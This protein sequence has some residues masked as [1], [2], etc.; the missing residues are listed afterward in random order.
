VSEFFS[1][2]TLNYYYKVWYFSIYGRNLAKAD[3]YQIGFD[4]AALW[5]YATLRAP[6]TYGVE[7]GFRFGE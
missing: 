4:L 2:T 7:V 3:R 1:G 6:Q 5:S